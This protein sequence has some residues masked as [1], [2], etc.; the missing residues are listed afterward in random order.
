V[1]RDLSDE[2]RRLIVQQLPGAIEAA[3]AAA[4][5]DDR[6]LKYLA[7]LAEA[8]EMAHP[9]LKDFVPPPSRRGRRQR[10]PRER[11]RVFR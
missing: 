6:R 11:I 5:K 9:L 10:R 3:A 1:K 4:A 2:Q 8:M 7:R